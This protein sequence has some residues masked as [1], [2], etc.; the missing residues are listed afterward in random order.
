MAKSIQNMIFSQFPASSFVNLQISIFLSQFY[1]EWA[2][3]A[4]E[5]SVVRVVFWRGKCDGKRPV[6]DRLRKFW[7]FCCSG[8]KRLCFAC[9]LSRKGTSFGTHKKVPTFDVEVTSKGCVLL[10]NSYGKGP[11]LERLESSD[12]RA[13]PVVQKSR[14]PLRSVLDFSRPR[15]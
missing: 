9:K 13:Q 12:I 4:S 14:S 11:V 8:A 2:R 7:Y 10:A 3:S 15:L 6:L 1:F 5:I